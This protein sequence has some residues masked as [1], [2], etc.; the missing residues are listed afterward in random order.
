MISYFYTGWSKLHFG[1]GHPCKDEIQDW[2]DNGRHAARHL[3]DA[4]IDGSY[5]TWWAT[6]E[7]RKI[8]PAS[9]QGDNLLRARGQV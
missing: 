3:L 7:H 4:D 2:E 9:Y 5:S 1:E 8:L 6:T